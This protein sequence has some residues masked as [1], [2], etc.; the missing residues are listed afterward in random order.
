MIKISNSEF[1]L[2]TPD[3]KNTYSFSLK[4]A[5]W[6]AKINSINPQ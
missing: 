5:Q 1:K 4:E 6:L 2:I 3:A